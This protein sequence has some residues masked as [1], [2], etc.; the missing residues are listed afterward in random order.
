MTLLQVQWWGVRI[1]T[2]VDRTVLPSTRRQE[3]RTSPFRPSPPYPCNWKQP[4]WLIAFGIDPWCE[5]SSF[6]PCSATP[7]CVTMQKSLCFPVPSGPLSHHTQH[8]DSLGKD[9]LKYTAP[10]G[11]SLMRY[12]PW[13]HTGKS[14]LWESLD[15]P[16]LCQIKRSLQN[17][18]FWGRGRCESE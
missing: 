1:G 2:K 8:I 10:W 18:L 9:C 14:F 3:R 6:L 16:S 17:C 4:C 11:V 15:G 7:L 5:F 12:R 13:L